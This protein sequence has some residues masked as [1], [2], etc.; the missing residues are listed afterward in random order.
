MVADPAS[1]VAPIISYCIP[2]V[3][4][5]VVTYRVLNQ[6]S[7]IIEISAEP[8]IHCC[9]RESRHIL[10]I[11]RL[12][13]RRL[14]PQM[15]DFLSRH[16]P[17]PLPILASARRAVDATWLAWTEPRLLFPHRKHSMI[18]FVKSINFQCSQRCVSQVASL[19]SKHMKP[20]SC[21]VR[22]RKY[23]KSPRTSSTT[24]RVSLSC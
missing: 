14:S 8:H 11:G 16:Q 19:L 18:Q 24:L 12:P 4:I 10:Y 2:Q 13:P 21:G 15:S 3:P 6:W 9:A 22:D 23:S 20:R 1:C 17:P 7:L 5:S